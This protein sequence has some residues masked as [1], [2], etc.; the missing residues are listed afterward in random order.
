MGRDGKLAKERILTIIS[1]NP[2]F[3]E[4]LSVS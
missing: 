2:I 4:K 1:R 3:K